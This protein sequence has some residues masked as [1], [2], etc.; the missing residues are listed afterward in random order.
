MNLRQLDVWDVNNEP[1]EVFDALECFLNN[2]DKIIN[3]VQVVCNCTS[4]IIVDGIQVNRFMDT[5]IYSEEADTV[6][7]LSNARYYNEQR[8][9]EATPEMV[10]DYF[11]QNGISCTV[12]SGEPQFG[13]YED[14]QIPEMWFCREGK[15]LSDALGASGT[16]ECKIYSN[17]TAS[18]SVGY[19][20]EGVYKE[21]FGVNVKGI[22][23]TGDI[24]A[25]LID[26]QDKRN[27]SI[28]EAI[29]IIEG[30]GFSYSFEDGPI[31]DQSS[32]IKPH[33]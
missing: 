10:V 31:I 14:E 4:S 3:P 2:K 8:D 16:N 26:E 15:V 6:L 21:L 13:I 7:C 18:I 33:M 25:F 20:K 24:W 19:V 27:I 17:S 30:K 11:D 29:R 12:S 5:L 22:I 1:L 23:Q 32:N 9:F 28:E